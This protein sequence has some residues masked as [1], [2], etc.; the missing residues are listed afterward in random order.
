LVRRDDGVVNHRLKEDL[1]ASTTLVDIAGRRRSSATL[2]GYHQGR[3]PRNKG[4]QY[5]AD[6]PTVEEIIAVMRAAGD[7]PDAVRLRGLIV[8]LWRAGLR[9]S[10]ALA[11]TESDLDSGRG[12]IL[13]RHGKGGK[14]REVGM[15]RW[16][17]EQLAPWLTLRATLPVGALFC[18]LRGPTRGRPWGPAGVRTQLHQ[19]AAR[20]RVRR[21]FAPHQLR[22]A[23][24]VEMSREGVPLLVIQRQLGH[25]NLAITSVYA[26]H[27]QH[28]N[29]AHRP[30]T[31]RTH[32]PCPQ[33]AA[34]ALNPR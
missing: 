13:V 11:L 23:H 6:P 19:A 21:R 2:P 4:L 33:R 29:R 31:T 27:R 17:W 18:V 14:R 22:H 1:M 9:I 7:D 12:A 26:R 10:E 34:A 30:R 3:P 28:R 16:A 25:A 24:A 5:P 15:D 8:V 32:D 20:A